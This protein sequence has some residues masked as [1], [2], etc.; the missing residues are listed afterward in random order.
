MPMKTEQTRSSSP[1]SRSA[2]RKPYTRPTQET[3]E[4]EGSHKAQLK[5]V[6][7]REMNNPG[8]RQGGNRLGIS[9]PRARTESLKNWIITEYEWPTQM[10][11]LQFLKTPEQRLRKE[12]KET[13]SWKRLQDNRIDM[14]ARG[15]KFIDASINGY[16]VIG[17]LRKAYDKTPN[18]YDVSF[19]SWGSPHVCLPSQKGS[20]EKPGGHT[21]YKALAFESL[22]KEFPWSVVLVTFSTETPDIY[23]RFYETTERSYH[24]L[25]VHIPYNENIFYVPRQ[26]TGEPRCKKDAVHALLAV[27]KWAESMFVSAYAEGVLTS[28]AK[29]FDLG[30]FVKDITARNQ[31]LI[32]LG[33]E[34]AD[35]SRSLSLAI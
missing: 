5:G 15:A 20:V 11:H 7:D 29:A 16:D 19:V 17:S 27:P 35:L 9:G 30:K 3:P 10:S 24:A 12:S 25:K 32:F 28:P 8:M 6:D 22:C 21:D 26:S 18:S 13:P 1:R 23:R 2:G 31:P 14:S 34:S 33:E 4:E